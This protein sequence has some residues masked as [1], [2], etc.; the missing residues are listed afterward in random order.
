MAR[1]L[2]YLYA[3]SSGGITMTDIKTKRIMQDAADAIKRIDVSI[4]HE[5]AVLV[6]L[7][8]LRSELADDVDTLV[9]AGI[10]EAVSKL[11]E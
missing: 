5:E 1:N 6:N 8:A 3:G 4:A 10:A 11:E 9:S 2:G 7:H